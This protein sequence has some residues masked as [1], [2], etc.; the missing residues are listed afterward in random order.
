MYTDFKNLNGAGF[1]VK[2]RSDSTDETFLLHYLPIDEFLTVQKNKII[3]GFGSDSTGEWIRFTRDVAGDI[4]KVFNLKKKSRKMS[5]MKLKI[6][7]L[8]FFG[9]G[10]VCYI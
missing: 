2:V 3:F 7:S 4:E 5:K 6:I 9:H 8:Q 1:Q 10:Q